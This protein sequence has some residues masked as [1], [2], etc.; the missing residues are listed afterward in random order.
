MKGSI[1]LGKLI[2]VK[3]PLQFPEEEPAKLACCCS[4]PTASIV[5]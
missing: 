2:I 5:K 4:N 1:I 3:S